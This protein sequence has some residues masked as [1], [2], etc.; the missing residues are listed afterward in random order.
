M[1]GGLGAL[2]TGPL[3]ETPAL[4][5][6]LGLARGGLSALHGGCAG[7]LALAWGFHLVRICLAW[8]EGRN[9]WGLL[10]RPSDAAS[11]VRSLLRGL[12]VPMAPSIRGRFTY[13]ERVSYF[14]F[15]V[16]VPLLALTGWTTSHPARS[17]ALVG[18][19]GL[20]LAALAHSAAGL[21]LVPFTIW[22]VYFAL[23]QPGALFW[24]GTWITGKSSWARVVRVRPDWAR[25][26]AE[27]VSPITETQDQ[28]PS[29]EELLESGNRAARE[30]RFTEA[31]QAY[32]EALEL[33]PGYS[34]ALFNLGVVRLRAADSSGAREALKRFLEQDPF[35]PAASRAQKL[36]EQ[37]R[38]EETRG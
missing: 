15:L 11:L 33:Y 6:A 9:P 35:G 22:H 31:E 13:R 38:G 14:A 10:P 1:I 29:V 2:V 17:F 37:I 21:L 24:N 23:V 32:S 16:A 4:A 18:T 34:Q 12:G 7:A 3:L 25:E 5:E 28:P 8:L 36:L 27:E 26:L 20:P 30:G 19:D